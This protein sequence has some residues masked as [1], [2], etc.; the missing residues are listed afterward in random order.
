MKSPSIGPFDKN[1]SIYFCFD[2]T[3]CTRAL[4]LKFIDHIEFAAG[5][6]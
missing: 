1:K 3:I 6:A 5:S 2:S 4:I